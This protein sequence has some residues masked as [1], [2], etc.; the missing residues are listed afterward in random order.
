MSRADKFLQPAEA[1]HVVGRVKG[2]RSLRT[3]E[4]IKKATKRIAAGEDIEKVATEL[5]AEDIAM[6]LSTGDEE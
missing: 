2:I 3:D 6:L 5:V 1:I 4:D